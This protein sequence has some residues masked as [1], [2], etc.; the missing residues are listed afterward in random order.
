M[1]LKTLNESIVSLLSLYST[2]KFIKKVTKKMKPLTL[3]QRKW[4]NTFKEFYSSSNADIKYADRHHK[5][6]FEMNA[7][8]TSGTGRI[9]FRNERGVLKA[10]VDIFPTNVEINN[11]NVKPDS[12]EIIVIKLKSDIENILKSIKVEKGI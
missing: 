12:S 5:Y 7:T 3:T 4:I 10:T 9:I 6:V 11:P 2:M 1:N 8:V